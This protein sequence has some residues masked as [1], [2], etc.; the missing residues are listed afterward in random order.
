MVRNKVIPGIR[1]LVKGEYCKTVS[2]DI[3]RSLPVGSTI[4]EYPAARAF[5]LVMISKIIPI[6]FRVLFGLILVNEKIKR[7]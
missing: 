4:I 7:G 5:K 3:P 6:M 2:T 1:K